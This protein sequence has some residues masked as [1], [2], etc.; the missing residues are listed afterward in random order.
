MST[1]AWDEN[2]ASIAYPHSSSDSMNVHDK[3][4]AWPQADYH[5]PIGGVN[6]NYI[7]S[8]RVYYSKNW[9]KCGLVL[10]FTVS[11]PLLTRNRSLPVMTIYHVSVYFPSVPSQ[12]CQYALQYNLDHKLTINTAVT[13]GDDIHFEKMT[14]TLPSE[15]NRYH[16]E[17]DK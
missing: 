2:Q 8:V 9:R 3:T 13:F 7:S 1:T 10:I 11:V 15:L 14:A 5:Q 16:R 4:A 6:D 12:S 17:I